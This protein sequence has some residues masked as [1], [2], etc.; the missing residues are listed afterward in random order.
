MSYCR[1]TT[2]LLYAD[3]IH[4]D[5]RGSAEFISNAC[6][7]VSKGKSVEVLHDSFDCSMG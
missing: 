7:R 4:L 3:N 5:G 1:G 6:D 2:A